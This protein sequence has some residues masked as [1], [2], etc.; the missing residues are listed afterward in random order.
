MA[1]TIMISL[2]PYNCDKYPQSEPPIIAPIFATTVRIV[3]WA[4]VYPSC[5]FKKVGYKS[6]V[7]SFF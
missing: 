3:T 2:R 5:A 6:C 1:E 7:P 4:G